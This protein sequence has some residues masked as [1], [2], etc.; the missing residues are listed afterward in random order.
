MK[1]VLS[2]FWAA[3]LRSFKGFKVTKTL[4]RSGPRVET[5]GQQ[6]NIGKWKGYKDEHWI[7]YKIRNTYI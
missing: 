5:V 4:N 1:S 7:Y 2:I 6:S 3:L